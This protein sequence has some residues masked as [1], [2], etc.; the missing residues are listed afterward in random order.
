M[1]V[2]AE[3]DAAEDGFTHRRSRRG[4]DVR[5]RRAHHLAQ[6]VAPHLAVDDQRAV[7]RS[8]PA[9]EDATRLGAQG[10][11]AGGKN[12]TAE[13]GGL[14]GDGARSLEEMFDPRIRKPREGDPGFANLMELQQ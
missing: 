9:D 14:Q 2:S 3:Q 5:P 4:D 11:N 8:H 1:P 13:R 7:V 6:V 10:K 12:L